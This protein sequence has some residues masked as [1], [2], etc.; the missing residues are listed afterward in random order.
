M[1]R[2][3]NTAVGTHELLL[4]TIYTIYTIYTTYTTYTTTYTKSKHYICSGSCSWDSR[5]APTYYIY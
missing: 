4:R 2:A 3:H 1:Q 5:T